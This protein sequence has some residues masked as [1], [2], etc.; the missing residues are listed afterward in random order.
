MFRLLLLA[1]LAIVVYRLVRGPRSARPV[2]GP[3]RHRVLPEQ[4]M[5]RCDHCGVFVPERE[6]VTD[7]AHRY[8]SPAHRDAGP[9]RGRGD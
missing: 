4:Q 1:L 7:G 8:C 5:V 6:A 3:P 9:S 2:G